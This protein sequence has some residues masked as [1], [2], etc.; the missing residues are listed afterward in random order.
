MA[1]HKNAELQKHRSA[2]LCSIPFYPRLTHLNE[3]WVQV[4]FA[5]FLQ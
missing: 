1:H 4:Y 3:A 5:A 2:F